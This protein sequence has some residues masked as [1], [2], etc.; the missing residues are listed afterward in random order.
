MPFSHQ[1]LKLFVI[2]VLHHFAD[3]LRLLARSDQQGI[4]GFD[5]HQVIHA[6]GCDK[7]PFGM[8]KVPLRVQRE[9]LLRLNYIFAIPA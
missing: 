7:F 5:D 6:H 9:A 8:N 4:I 1:P 2:Q 3:V